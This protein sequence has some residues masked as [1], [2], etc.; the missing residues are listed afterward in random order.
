MATLV[1]DIETVGENFETLDKA[2]QDVLTRWIKRE[3]ASEADYERGL[4][5]LKNGLGFSPLTGFV[6]AIG[7]YDPDRARGAVYFQ[8]PD[9]SIADHEHDGFKYCVK[10]EAELLRTFWE[11][12]EKYDEFVT[13][14]G[15]AFD[16]PFLM[17]R[18]AVHHSKP[19]KNLI[20]QRYLDK[21][22]R[23]VR[24]ID[25]CDQLSFYGAS[26]RKPSLHMVCRAFDLESPKVSAL[27]ICSSL[28]KH[29]NNAQTSRRMRHAN[30]Q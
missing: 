13:F 20:S 1:F 14:N 25:L 30:L 27:F 10:T 29:T 21:Q 19:S 16:V 17:I 12:A 28:H 7:V 3:A 24:H 23:G 6:V 5:T 18:S 4:E 2:S 9:A 22:F 26:W 11:I 15:R 8:A